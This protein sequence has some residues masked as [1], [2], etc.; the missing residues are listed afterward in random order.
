MTQIWCEQALGWDESPDW[1]EYTLA[2]SEEEAWNRQKEHQ[3][4]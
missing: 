1:V 2:W 3:L 4:G